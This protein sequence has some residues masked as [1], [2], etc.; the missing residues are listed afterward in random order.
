MWSISASDI[1][2]FA[3]AS[4]LVPAR[5]DRIDGQAVVDAA[6]ALLDT[7]VGR[8]DQVDLAEL[9]VDL[10]QQSSRS[11]ASICGPERQQQVLRRDLVGGERQP[12]RALEVAGIV[13]AES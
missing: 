7:V 2:T 12:T 9:R 5:I 11:A 1:V 6:E 10:H 3:A 4:G 13:I 8:A